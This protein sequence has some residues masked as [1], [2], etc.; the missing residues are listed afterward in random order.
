MLIWYTKYWKAR[1]MEKITQKLQ[2]PVQSSFLKP[3]VIWAFDTIFG[4]P[5]GAVFASYDA[6]YSFEGI[7]HIF[8]SSWTRMLAWLEGHAKS[9]GKLRRRHFVDWGYNANTGLQMPMSDV[10]H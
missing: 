1:D 9:T 5:S 10:P 2:K 8:G 6:I 4:Y 7:Q 3:C